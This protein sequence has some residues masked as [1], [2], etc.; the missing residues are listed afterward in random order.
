MLAE[1]GARYRPAKGATAIVMDPRDGE[2]LAVANWPRVD[3][4]HVTQAPG[5]GAPE[6]R[7]ADLLRAGL[8]LQGVHHGRRARGRQGHAETRSSSCPRRSWS[9][10]AGSARR[11]ARAYGTLDASGI[12]QKSSNIGT[13]MIGQ[14]LGAHALRPVGAPLRLRQADRRRPARRA[15]RHRAAALEVLRLLDGQPAD[16]PGRG[17]HADADGD[18][19]RGDRQRRHP[20]P[21]ADRQGGR[22]Q[23]DAAAEGAA[24]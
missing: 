15:D 24:A 4:N 14:R 13:I 8:D 16:R 7:R 21:A 20:A 9:P 23:A 6:P 22:R 18:R 11:T 12:I 5:L 2:L 10:T 17:G 3:A 19:L 1:I